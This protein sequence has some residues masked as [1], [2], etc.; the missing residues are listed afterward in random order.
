MPLFCESYAVIAK[1]G[2]IVVYRNIN[3]NNIDQNIYKHIMNCSHVLGACI[4]T[5]CVVRGLPSMVKG[6]RLRA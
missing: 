3:C 4:D 1:V 5:I 2:R 6:A